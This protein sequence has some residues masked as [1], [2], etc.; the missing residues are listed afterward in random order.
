MKLIPQCVF[1]AGDCSSSSAA[2]CLPVRRQCAA[3]P[4]VTGFLLLLC[5]TPVVA[6]AVSK[7]YFVFKHELKTT[8]KNDPKI[9]IFLYKISN[10]SKVVLQIMLKISKKFALLMYVV[11]EKNLGASII[12]L[13]IMNF[14][15]K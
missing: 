4:G 1:C 12:I 13:V 7:F 10:I 15:T 14:Y 6:A 9:I 8:V 3:A 5:A 2:P 11:H